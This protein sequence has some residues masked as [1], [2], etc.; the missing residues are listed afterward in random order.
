[1]PRTTRSTSLET[2]TARFRLVKDK[3]HWTAVGVSGLAL[4]YRRGN[5]T[6]SWTVRLRQADGTYITDALGLADDH[7]EAD[8][9]EVLSYFQAQAAAKAFREAHQDPDHRRLPGVFT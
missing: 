4:G 8:E 6:S 1:M 9:R 5:K 3:Y 2:R 7:H